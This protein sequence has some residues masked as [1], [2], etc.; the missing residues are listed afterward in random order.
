MHA[1][2][3]GTENTGS[4]AAR[5]F[6]SIQPG[7]RCFFAVRIAGSPAPSACPDSL[8]RGRVCP[9]ASEKRKG[10]GKSPRRDLFRCISAASKI[11]EKILKNQQKVIDKYVIVWYNVNVSKGN[12]KAHPADY[13]TGGDNMTVLEVIALLNLLS[14]VIFG[15]IAIAKK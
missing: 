14:V 13:L 11:I 12:G 9:S 2:T 10:R 8:H 15:V 4:R 6:S 3:Q 7:R 5:R 1:R